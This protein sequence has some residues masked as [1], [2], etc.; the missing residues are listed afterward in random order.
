[1]EPKSVRE[2]PESDQQLFSIPPELLAGEKKI[3]QGRNLLF[4]IGGV[5][6]VVGVF[7]YYSTEDPWI[8]WFAFGIDAFVGSLFLALG[9]WVRKRPFFS[10]LLGLILYI[11]FILLLASFNLRSVA[12]GWIV[13]LFFI[14]ALVSSVKAARDT[15]AL[16]RLS[17]PAE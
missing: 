14:L 8:A 5:Q 4:F 9:F 7:E 12:A 16:R 2:S 10:L 11:L 15:E 3:R 17:H 1:M 13:K 6:L